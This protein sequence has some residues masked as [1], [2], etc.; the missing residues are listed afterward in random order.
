MGLYFCC[1]LV[2][3]PQQA[4][5]LLQTVRLI[6]EFGKSGIVTLVLMSQAFGYWIGHRPEAPWDWPRFGLSLTGML[7]LA[8]GS[9]AWNQIQ[10]RDADARMP[11]TKNRPLPSKRLTLGHAIV[12]ASILLLSGLGLLFTVSGMLG[13]QGIAAVIFYN[14]LYTAWWKPRWAYA[15]IPG[16]IPGAMPIWMGFTAS[17]DA[18]WHPAGIYL[19]GLLVFWQMPLFWSLAIRYAEDYR[20]GGFPTLPVAR[21]PAMTVFQ[22]S[23]WLLGY[24]LVIALAPVI[25]PLT[26]LYATLAT[27]LIVGL[28]WTWWRYRHAPQAHW[29]R[30][31]LAVNLSLV[32]ILTALSLDLAE[33]YWGIWW[34][35]FSG[36]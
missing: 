18:P 21:G 25:F 27:P 11:R 19:F 9:S 7:L 31:F 5:I 34:H 30:F 23:V 6:A 3:A 4:R 28:V 33:P 8:L 22:I 32:W 20:L 35:R 36:Q 10:E 29:L 12:L 2:R 15:A 13:F 26:W 14:G 17:S 16:S 24:V 1:S